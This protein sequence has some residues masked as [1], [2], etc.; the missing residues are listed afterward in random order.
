M[1]THQ[2]QLRLQR[3]ARRQRAVAPLSL[4][5][6]IISGLAGVVGIGGVYFGVRGLESGWG[7][8]IVLGALGAGSVAVAAGMLGA[9]LSASLGAVCEAAR[10]VASGD[11]RVLLPNGPGG[12]MA[13]LGPAFNQMATTIAEDLRRLREANLSLEETARRRTTEAEERAKKLES[14]LCTASQDLRA[15][16]LSIQGFANL[17]S[18]GLNRRLDEES[19]EHLLRIRTNAEAMDVLLRDLLEVARVRKVQEPREWVDSGEIVA[20]VLH[21]LEPDTR[22]LR[23]RVKVGDRLPMVS[24]APLLLARVFRNLVENAIKFMGDQPSPAITVGCERTAQ[25]HRFFVRDN[26]V[27]IKAEDA[28]RIFGLFARAEGTRARGSGIGLAIVQRIVEAHG[29]RVWVESRPGEGSTFWVAVPG[30]MPP[31]GATTE[32]G[33]NS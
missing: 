33:I 27:G 32:S 23:V 25:G 29:G 15:P 11:F 4:Y 5:A 24:Y 30:A 7:T 22:R 19:R 16:V 26:G 8:G 12:E 3:A 20:T 1:A 13:R 28:E 6:A 10:L 21:D 9:R 14:F 31:Q 18:R 2:V 17:L